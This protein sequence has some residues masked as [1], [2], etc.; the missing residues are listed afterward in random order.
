MFCSKCGNETSKEAK[1]CKNCGNP[2]EFK[3]I[4]KN[5]DTLKEK[6]NFWQFFLKSFLITTSAFLLLFLLIGGFEEDAAAG[7]LGTLFIG[8]LISFLITVV[9]KGINRKDKIQLSAEELKKYEGLEGW[10]TL[11]IL[12]LI[13]SVGYSLYE[14]FLMWNEYEEYGI[15]GILIGLAFLVFTVYII[16]LF[17]KRKIV[18][19]RWYIAFLI[20]SMAINIFALIYTDAND[21]EMQTISKDTGRAV[22]S[23][24]IWVPYMLISKRVKATFTK[25]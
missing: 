5:T 10:L 3:E 1:F 6:S 13:I 25:N 23:V 19:P 22:L 17:F 9:A 4:E 16:Y 18:F 8:G 20:I 7:V 15:F 11:V 2:T 24:I 14:L 21:P 12:G